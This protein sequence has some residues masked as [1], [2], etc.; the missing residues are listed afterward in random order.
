MKLKTLTLAI[1]F[2]GLSFVKAQTADEIVNKYVDAMGGSAKLSSLKSTKMS[3][4]MSTQ[5]MDIPVVFTK[6][7]L[8]GLRVEMEINGTSNYRVANTTSGSVY[9]P[10]AGMTEP[11]VMGESDLK[12]YVRQMDVQGSL[13]DYK[14]KGSTIELGAKE[15]IDGSEAYRINLTNKD[16]DV[17]TYFIGAKTS[18]ILRQ[19]SKVTMNGQT[20]EVENNYSDY[21]QNAD[22]YWFPY[23]ISSQQNTVSFDKIETNL[24]IDESIFK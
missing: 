23:N 19:I 20:I 9:M 2:I 5:G 8:K 24:N 11:V 3:G 17:I 7:H 16:G 10:V 22:G 21:K 1:G 18:R 12:G 6:L 13:F 4:T 14:S 15:T